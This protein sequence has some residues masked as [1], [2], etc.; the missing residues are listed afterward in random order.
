MPKSPVAS[1]AAMAASS[2]SQGHNGPGTYSASSEKIKPRLTRQLSR[3]HSEIEVVVG[4]G[5]DYNAS[6][7]DDELLGNSDPD[8]EPP[9]SAAHPSNPSYK[10]LNTSDHEGDKLSGLCTDPEDDEDSPDHDEDEREIRYSNPTFPLLGHTSS[11]EDN[12]ISGGLETYSLPNGMVLFSPE[13]DVFARSA[14][15][16]KNIL[17]RP[18]TLTNFKNFSRNLPE[19]MKM[20]PLKD[21]RV[22]STL[23]NHGQMIGRLKEDSITNELESTNLNQLTKEELY[24]M[25]KTSEREWN[26]KLRKALE[27]KAALEQKLSQMKPDTNT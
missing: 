16:G 6:K 5:M 24:L 27:E 7:S 23:S 9:M 4:D 19:S 11:S 3:S 1:T 15:S 18:K 8:T 13:G 22:K 25:W 17:V 21:N 12:L 20:L 14:S 26:K 10:L 2:S